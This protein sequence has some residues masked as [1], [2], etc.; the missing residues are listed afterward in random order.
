MSAPPGSAAAGFTFTW[1]SQEIKPITLIPRQFSKAV[2]G[3]GPVRSFEEW[4]Q[5]A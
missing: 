2:V 3:R 5:I 1:T 4:E